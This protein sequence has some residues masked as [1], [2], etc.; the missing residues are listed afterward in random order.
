MRVSVKE[1]SYKS[2]QSR[3]RA[4]MTELFPLIKQTFTTHDDRS[5]DLFCSFYANGEQLVEGINLTYNTSIFSSYVLYR[6]L[7]EV[8]IKS[9]FL[10][11]KLDNNID[12]NKSK[13]FWICMVVKEMLDNNKGRE[14]KG[15]IKEL[16]ENDIIPQNITDEEIISN[17][18][19]FSFSKMIS[20]IELNTSNEHE[21]NVIQ[22]I[23][24]DYTT[25]CSFT[26]SGVLSNRYMSRLASNDA[27]IINYISEKHL[28]SQVIDYCFIL[29]MSLINYLVL[30]NEC[31]IKYKNKIDELYLIYCEI[32]Q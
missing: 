3:N 12:T 11:K 21:K 31:F 17:V 2:I 32:D 5:V 7:I 9:Y 16:K 23:K 13:I 4:I 15:I 30:Y 28:L 1:K 19:E 10:T 18:N 14:K 26:H 25:A 6:S 8:S 20:F 24:N 27:V 22:W 29:E